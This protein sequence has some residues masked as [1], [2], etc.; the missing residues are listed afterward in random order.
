MVPQEKP[1]RFPMLIDEAI[2]LVT[3]QE[4]SDDHIYRS[5]QPTAPAH[6]R[7]HAHA[8]TRTEDA[9]GVSARGSPVHCVSWSLPRH[10]D[11][12]GL[13]AL[14]V[15][16]GRSWRFPSFPQC[17]NHGIEVLLAHD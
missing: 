16:S 3:R 8:P 7:R 12:R 6:D 9:G 13:A 11:G 17:G 14:S 5:Y 10:R 4:P 1:A 15:A 2:R